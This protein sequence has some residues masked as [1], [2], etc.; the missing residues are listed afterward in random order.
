M[1]M[2]NFKQSLQT[3][4]ESASEGWRP[5]AAG[6]ASAM[7]AFRGGESAGLPAQAQVDDAGYLPTHAWSMLGGDLFEDDRRLVVRLE[8]PGMAKEDFQ[9][10][11][12]EDQLVVRGEKR[13][14]RES[15]DGRY[16]MLQCAYGSFR[17]EVALPVP[18]SVGGATATYERGVLR[19]ELPK[20]E[21]GR[22]KSRTIAVQ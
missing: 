20:A 12:I 11:V 5:F 19:I 9:I 22:L 13:F 21:P 6:A 7:T 8:V 2:K 1:S 10:E 18:V 4:L 3:L 14:S 17:R 15:S 16:R